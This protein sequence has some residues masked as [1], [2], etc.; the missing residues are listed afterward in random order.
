MMTTQ[1]LMRKIAEAGIHRRRRDASPTRGGPAVTG[2]RRGDILRVALGQTGGHEL[3]DAHYAVVVQSEVLALSTVAVVPLR[4]SSRAASWHVP[5]TIGG[6][7]TYALVEQM[8]ATDIETRLRDWICNIAGTD[9][10][11]EIDDQLA[12]VLG[13]HEDYRD[14][15][16]S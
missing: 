15:D 11:A 1:E 16:V 8:R 10:M 6:K 13:L 12:M 3:R 4:N 9:E 5:V 7:R 14:A 2:I